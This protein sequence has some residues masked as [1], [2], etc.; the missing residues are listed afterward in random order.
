MGKEKVDAMEV[1]ESEGQ[2]CKFVVMDEGF[3]LDLED[4]LRVSAYMVG[5]SRSRI[6]CKVVVGGGKGSGV[7]AT[8][9]AI[10]R[11]SEC[12]DATW[13]FESEM[14][15]IGRVHHPN[16]LALRAYYYASDEKLF[17]TDFIRNKSL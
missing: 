9:M 10:R 13:K 14:E 15:A 1:V 5:K 11:L 2:K 16:I 8:V 7:T 3:G 4:L 6:M 12:D 17:V